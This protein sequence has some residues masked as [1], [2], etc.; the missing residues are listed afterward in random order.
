MVAPTGSRV[1]YHFRVTL[2][3]KTRSVLKSKFCDVGAK[4]RSEATTGSPK[5][6][7]YPLC[8]EKTHVRRVDAV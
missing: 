1:I 7:P 4:P 2:S 3:E 8:G 6:F 5:D